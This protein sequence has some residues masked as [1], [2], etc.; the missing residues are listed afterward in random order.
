MI[1]R[2]KLLAALGTSALASGVVASFIA[3]ILGGLCV[4]FITRTPRYST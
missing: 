2:R 4:A 1:T 3:A